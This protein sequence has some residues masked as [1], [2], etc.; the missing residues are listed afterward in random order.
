MDEYKENP[1]VDNKNLEDLIDIK[2]GWF[3]EENGI[4]LWPQLY[5]TDITRFY[6]NVLGKKS[7]V[8]RTECEYKQRKA[9]IYFTQNFISEVYYNNISDE[10]KYFYLKTKG[11]PSQRVLSNPYDVWVLVKKDFKYEV[12]GAILSAYFTCTAGLLG[13]C[14]HVADL[15]L[16]WKQLYLLE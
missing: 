9:Y 2:N 14:N 13:S 10:S 12:G 6:G 5:L 15:L 4:K 7:I 11:L 1:V 16:E 3:G 8:Q